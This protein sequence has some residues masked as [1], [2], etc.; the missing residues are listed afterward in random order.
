MI[1]AELLALI[2]NDDPIYLDQVDRCELEQ[3]HPA[4][5]AVQAHYDLNYHRTP[6]PRRPRRHPCEPRKDAA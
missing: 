5:A 3:M 2:P 4:V 6:T 1:A